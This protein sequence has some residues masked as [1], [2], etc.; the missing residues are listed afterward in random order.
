MFDIVQTVVQLMFIQPLFDACDFACRQLDGR[1]KLSI[2]AG[3]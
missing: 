1:C 2:E 3:E